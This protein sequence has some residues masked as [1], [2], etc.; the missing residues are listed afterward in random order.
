LDEE[1]LESLMPSLTQS[2]AVVTGGGQGIGAAIAEKLAESG[3]A[4][5]ISGRHEEK[6]AEVAGRIRTRSGRASYVVGDVV[7]E[8]HVAELMAHAAG[9]GGSIE[10]LVNNAGVAGPSAPLEEISVEDW[11]RTLAVN[12]TGVFLCCRAAIPYLRRAEGARI[13]NIGSAAGKKAFPNRTPYTTSKLGLVGL[14]RTLAH[15]LGRDGITV[16]TISPGLVEGD[17]LERVL[18]S[19]AT[20]RGI[21]AEDLRRELVAETALGRG[22]TEADIAEMTLFLCSAAADNVTGQDLNVNAGSVLV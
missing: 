21:D 7:D 13:V 15:E 8:G 20:S 4:V 18:A 12:L 2:S 6:L 1:K 19:M 3:A 9:N 22:V 16:N 17:R 10:I 14:T 11:S 5:T